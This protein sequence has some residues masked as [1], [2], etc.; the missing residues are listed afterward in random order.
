MKNKMNKRIQISREQANELFVR[1][2]LNAPEESFSNPED[3]CL[4]LEN[5]F[6][7]CCD[8]IISISARFNSKESTQF[9]ALCEA[10]FSQI[11]QLAPLNVYS[12]QLFCTHRLHTRRANTAGCICYNKE[13]THVLVVH[14]YADSNLYSFPKG[15]MCK[16]ESYVEAAIRETLEETGIDVSERIDETQYMIG[17]RKNK[18]D[19]KMFNV[20]LDKSL[21]DNFESPSPLEVSRIRLIKITE[22][23]SKFQKKGLQPDPLTIMLKPQIIKWA[24]A[25]RNSISS[26][27]N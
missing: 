4:L 2:I 11:P 18:S 14:Q 3:F 16:D 25:H 22:I 7:Y 9:E 12:K 23:P 21:S 20:V 1:F 10:L 24:N 8:R 15:K 5:A 19:V 13:L 26:E 6:Y 17:K 27:M